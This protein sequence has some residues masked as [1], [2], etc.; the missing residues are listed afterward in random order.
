VAQVKQILLMQG[1]T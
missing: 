1:R